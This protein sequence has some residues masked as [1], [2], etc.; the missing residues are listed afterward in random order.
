MI[1]FSSIQS[2]LFTKVTSYHNNRQHLIEPYHLVQVLNLRI[3]FQKSLF[4]ILYNC[5]ILS[6][7]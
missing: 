5:A 6:V 7:V 3:K 1:F 4:I 2:M